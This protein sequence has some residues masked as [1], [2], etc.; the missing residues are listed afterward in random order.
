MHKH[1]AAKRAFT[2]IE[3]LIVV[4][5]LGI[6][7][8]IVIPQFT[9]AADDAQVSSAKSQLQTARAQIELYRF[10]E[11]EYPV[12]GGGML[13][14]SLLVDN[15]YLHSAPGNPLQGNSTSVAAAAAEGVGWVWEVDATS[16]HARL[17][18]VGADNAKADW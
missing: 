11:N 7:A 5:I 17:Y 13:D 9:S 1:R 2:L 10:T 12:D 15:N 8:A 16:G 4:V 18:A 14:W 3:I 6:L